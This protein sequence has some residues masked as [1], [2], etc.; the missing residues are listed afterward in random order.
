MGVSGSKDSVNATQFC[1]TG[2][3]LSISAD[4]DVGDRDQ[5]RAE[6]RDTSVVP[7][8]YGSSCLAL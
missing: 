7:H 8:R 6:G 5:R 2:E 1:D 3:A 4:T